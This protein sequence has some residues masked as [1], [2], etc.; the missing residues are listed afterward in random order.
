MSLLQA[1]VGRVRDVLAGFEARSLPLEGL[2]GFDKTLHAGLILKQDM[3]AEL[4]APETGSAQLALYSSETGGDCVRL[5]GKGLD[6]LKGMS[7]AFAVVAILK[8]EQLDQ[9]TYYRFVQRHQRLMDQPGWMVKMTGGK[10]WVRCAPAGG[11]QPSLELVARTFVDRIHQA[12][13]T[14]QG[15]ELWFVTGNDG[16]VAR[17]AQEA[18]DLAGAVRSIKEGVW[19]ERG[20]DYDS[21]QLTGHC[22]QCADKK[23]CAG[24]HKIEARVKMNRRRAAASQTGEAS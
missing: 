14:V 11:T 5:I 4:G 13:E 22:G 8:G 7:V 6:G 16:L 20:F 15:V 9:E 21:C 17:L 23:T 24:V 18:Q 10:I 1:Q 12:F 19:K 2:T 3:T